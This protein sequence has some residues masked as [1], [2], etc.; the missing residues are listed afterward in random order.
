MS[1]IPSVKC[2]NP[3]EW[4]SGAAIIV[5]SRACSGI[6]DSSEAAGSSESGWLRDAPFGV[7]VVPD[8]RITTRPGSAGGTTSASSPCSMSSSS[9][10]SDRSVS[11]SCQAMNR[12]RRTAAS[13]TRSVNSSSKTIA[14]G[15]SRLTTSVICGAANAVLRYRA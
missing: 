14:R 1:P 5:V 9:V 3:H 13:L 6:F 2:A 11:G 4:N 12:L 8:V 7:P 15:P 10:G